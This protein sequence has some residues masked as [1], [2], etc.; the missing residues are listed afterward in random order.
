MCRCA[1]GAWGRVSSIG[2]SVACSVAKTHC[3]PSGPAAPNP[4]DNRPEFRSPPLLSGAQA[5]RQELQRGAAHRDQPEGDLWGPVMRIAWH[6]GQP[7]HSQPD[8]QTGTSQS[9]QLECVNSPA[10]P[11]PSSPP[12]TGEGAVHGWGEAGGHHLGR[13]LNWHQPAG[14]KQVA[15]VCCCTAAKCLLLWWQN[16]SSYGDDVLP[17]R[18][19]DVAH[20]AKTCAVPTCSASTCCPPCPTV[21]QADWRVPNQR[22]RCHITLELPWSADKAVQVATILSGLG[23]QGTVEG[24]SPAGVVA[25]HAAHAVQFEDGLQHSP[26]P[27]CPARAAHRSNLGARTAATR[28]ACCRKVDAVLMLQPAA[29]CLLDSAPCSD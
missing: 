17:W 28:W 6:C 7:V 14:L 11:L 1:G 15:V 2:L 8:E 18:L 29:L 25:M 24:S 21:Q 19:A 16:T 10:H 5:G 4:T 13:I 27:P 22:R 23:R 26:T 3:H 9:K 12:R 20:W